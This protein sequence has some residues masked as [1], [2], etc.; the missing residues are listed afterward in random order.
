MITDVYF[1]RI[2]GVSTSIGTFIRVLIQLG[3][4]VTL[5]APMYGEDDDK[6]DQGFEILRIPSHKVPFDPEDRLMKRNLVDLHLKHLVRQRFDILHI[7]TP[8]IAHYSGI[9]LARRLNIPVVETYHTYFEEYLYH[10]L[11]F[12]PKKSMQWLARRFT[13]SQSKAVDAMVVPS[14]LMH[15]VLVTYGV[16][17]P[18]RII[19]TGLENDRFEGGD[20]SRFRERYNIS[21]S[22]PVLCHVGRSAHEK[23]IDFLLEMLVQ[24]KKTMPDILLLLAGEGPAQQ[25]LRNRSASLGLNNNI[26][27]MNYLDRDTE[28]KDCYR[29]GD[30]FVFASRTE[31]QG[32][33]LLE[34]MAL[35][36]P[37]VS[38]A[39]LGTVDILQPEKGALIAEEDVE[40][41]AHKVIALLKDD[42]LRHDKGVEAVDYAHTWSAEDTTQRLVELYEGVVNSSRAISLAMQQAGEMS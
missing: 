37:V 40:D 33:V 22:R 25:H 42:E 17:T 39:V 35:G 4:H 20:G 24:V 3:H 28:L 15:K 10:Y 26:R 6:E 1:P 14:T 31:T 5:I 11:R 19:P 2:N 16:E 36:V 9:R 32:L 13:R 8:F 41:F 23:N 38:T 29:A 30:A 7:Q 12:M 34:A 27:F 21:L 18:L